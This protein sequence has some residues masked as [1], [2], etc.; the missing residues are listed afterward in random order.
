MINAAAISDFFPTES[1]V[2]L[3]IHSMSLTS[4][5]G[6]NPQTINHIGIVLLIV[7]LFERGVVIRFAPIRFQI[8][9]VPTAMPPLAS[10]SVPL[11]S[12]TEEDLI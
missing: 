6:N 1:L 3:L 10:W 4:L 5:Y 8:L 12:D 7:Y 2:H 11:G 9:H